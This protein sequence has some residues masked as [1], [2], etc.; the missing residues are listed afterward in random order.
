VCDD[1]QA[2]TSVHAL[3]ALGARRSVRAPKLLHLLRSALAKHLAQPGR[4]RA[5]R[6]SSRSGT[7]ESYVCIRFNVIMMFVA[8]LGMGIT[9][10]LRPKGMQSLIK[11]FRQ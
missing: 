9:F 10:S 2:K 3:V 4:D 6:R 11:S 8:L 5:S 1:P 7:F